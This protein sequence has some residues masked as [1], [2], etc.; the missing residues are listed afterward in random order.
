VAI[1]V[2][3][4]SAAMVLLLTNMQGQGGDGEGDA[5]YEAPDLFDQADALFQ[6]FIDMNSSVSPETAGAA[7]WPR[8]CK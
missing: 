7:T 1:T 5:A 2:L 8:S 4:A 3:A 6:E